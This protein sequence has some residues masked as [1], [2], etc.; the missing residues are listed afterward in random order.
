[1][2]ERLA[3]AIGAD[4]WTALAVFSLGVLLS[5]ALIRFGVQSRMRK[6]LQ[7]IDTL[8]SQAE[9]ASR[10]AEEERMR[11][12][13][14]ISERTARISTLEAAVTALSDRLRSE[15][16]ARAAALERCRQL[17]ELE[18]LV[19]TRAEQLEALHAETGELRAAVA[20]STAELTAE[21]NAA[22]E[23][24]VLLQ[25][26]RA[27]LTDTFKSLAS[28]ALQQHAGTFLDLARAVLD[29]QQLAAT[30]ELEMRRRSLDG[31]MA[32]LRATPQKVDA[33]IAAVEQTRREAYGGL[34]QELRQVGETQE[35][36]RAETSNLAAALRTPQ[37]RGRWGEMQL[38]RVVELA[39]LV[40]HCDFV[41][42]PTITTADR[43]I[44]PDLVVRLPGERCVVVDAKAPLQAYLEAH[45]TRDDAVR[46]GRLADHARQLRTHLHALGSKAYWRSLRHTP[47]FVVM[48]LP[49]E[50]FF[51]AALEQDPGLIEL[52]V[53]DHVLIATPT[54]L[55][56]LLRAV[57]YAWRQERTQENAS[58]I[59]LLGK[60]LH[61]R[62]RALTEHF[63]ALRKGLES[64]ADAYNAAVG[65][66]EHRVL[67]AARRL[68]DFGAGAGGDIPILQSYDRHLR[69]LGD[70]RALPS[71]ASAGDLIP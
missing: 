6:L 22:A 38:R 50:S 30:A 53:N 54:T 7:S 8:T 59:C 40:E 42:Q 2:L 65:S 20:K 9:A 58:A 4:P 49:G 48:F 68:H 39:G 51:A 69:S 14:R 71:P 31:L 35:R 11:S 41:T 24:L 67:P 44:R 5:A 55:I 23:K 17:P 18:A 27:R 1:M 10:G 36:L 63:T 32:P 70:S 52:G 33:K 21:R 19:R 60:E 28:D 15:C 3:Q 61:E 16:E 64:A 57:A 62:V 43:T 37:I 45:E 25:E 46:A 12:A 13:E 34:I 29:K 26:A 47:E 66:L 56:A